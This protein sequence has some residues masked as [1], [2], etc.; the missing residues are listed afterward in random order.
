MRTK[1]KTKIKKLIEQRQTE[2]LNAA[3]RVFS[4][5]GF[6]KTT[7]EQVAVEAGLGKGTIY[8]Y[9]KSKKELFLAVGR[10]G[11]DKLKD[12]MIK[13]IEQ[14]E[15]PVDRIEKAIRTY[16]L[17]FQ[18]NTDL[19]NIFMYEQSGFKNEIRKKYFENY[20]GHVNRMQETFKSA[21]KKRLIKEV[22]IDNSIVILISMLNGL[23]YMWQVEGMKYSLESKIPA[24]LEIFLTGILKDEKRKKRYERS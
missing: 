3:N 7:I 21:M 17:F 8:Q 9:F 2:I 23:V 16:L 1:D 19:A 15:D 11:M 22:D 10:N 14:E 13:E 24:I 18:K 6:A 5:Y 20:Y 4:R 12:I